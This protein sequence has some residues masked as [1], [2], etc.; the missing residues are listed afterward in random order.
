[1]LLLVVKKDIF[2]G[3]KKFRAPQDTD[4]LAGSKFDGPVV[5]ILTAKVTMGI[6]I[7]ACNFQVAVF[8]KL[9]SFLA[10]S[11][12]VLERFFK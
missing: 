3:F 9:V 7:L 8:A 12:D 10:L 2:V 4:I 1:M 5:S 11:V 6:Y